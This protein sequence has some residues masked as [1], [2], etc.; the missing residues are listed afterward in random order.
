[1]ATDKRKKKGDIRTGYRL[2]KQFQ[3]SA[4]MAEACS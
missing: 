2:S 3:L 4:H 1:M